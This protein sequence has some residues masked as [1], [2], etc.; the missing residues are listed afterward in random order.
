MNL[1][2]ALSTPPVV[3]STFQSQSSPI[4]SSKV[5][6][7][8]ATYEKSSDIQQMIAYDILSSHL[9]SG[10]EKR[11][12][13]IGC[14]D[15]RLTAFIEKNTS[16]E[17]IGIDSSSEMISFAKKHSNENLSF[18]ESDITD[19]SLIDSIGRFDTIFS[20]NTL[21]WV[22]DQE[23]ALK[24]IYNMLED[25][26]R[27]QIQLFSPFTTQK[28]LHENMTKLLRQEKWMNY[29]I[30]FSFPLQMEVTTP[31]DYDL[32]LRKIGFNVITCRAVKYEFICTKQEIIDGLKSWLPHLRVIPEA[33]QK[34]EFLTDFV[35]ML[36]KET[37]QSS[38]DRPKM[39]L[40]PWVI[41]A[42]K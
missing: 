17:V 16:V 30:N 20:F 3:E 12:L 9:F 22:Q 40:F 38:S 14:G 28:L 5:E 26:G 27:L 24:N 1:H 2:L 37:G 39:L 34:E 33:H 11:I 36:L 35:D 6:W 25:H 8:P 23:T 29:F 21:H 41:Q 31:L 15:G 18:Y 13:D 42:I 7:D 19:C 32:I 10:D 4:H